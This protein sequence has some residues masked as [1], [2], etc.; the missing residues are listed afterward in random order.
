MSSNQNIAHVT[1]AT[2]NSR[3]AALVARLDDC[4][5]SGDYVAV[6]RTLGATRDPAAIA[7][8][9]SLLGS[10]GPIAEAAIAGLCSFGEAARPALREC[11]E[12]LDY[13]MIRH[14]HRVLSAL[15]DESSRRWLRDDDQERIA[16]YLER[17]GFL[18]ILWFG[19]IAN[20]TD[21]AK[22]SA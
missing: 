12:S 8:L 19:P 16:A 5:G 11:V 13:E 4:V 7:P 10:V 15:G 22:E 2:S 17:R 20:E 14:G 3:I 9:A 6:I 18:H 1:S 21:E